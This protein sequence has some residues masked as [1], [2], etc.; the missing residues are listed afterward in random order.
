MTS[1]ITATNLTKH[2]PGVVALDDLTIDVPQGSIYGF[3]GANGAGKTTAIKILAG[4]SRPTSG[5]ASVAGIPLTAGES[6]KAKIGYLGQEPRFY[7]WMTG[8]QVLAYVGGFYP[9]VEEPL[10]RRIA[11]ILDRVGIADAADRPTR[12]YSGGMRQRL[13]IAQALVGR[14]DVLLLDEP[15][16]APRSGGSAGRARPDVQPPRPRHDLLLDPHP[17]RRPAGVRSRGDHRQGPAR[18]AAATADLLASFTHD[19]VRVV[20]RGSRRRDRQRAAGPAGRGRRAA[21]R[22]RWRSIHLHGRGDRPTPRI[23]S[24]LPSHGLPSRPV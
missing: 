23:A 8:R 4:L 14:P 5:S 1:A 2:F 7:G 13:G 10:H 18:A 3:L 19:R 21:R 15:A 24:R 20:L 12:T 17:G 11:E 6:Y 22:P 16:S 9:H